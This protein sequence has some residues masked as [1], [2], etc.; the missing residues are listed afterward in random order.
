TAEGLAALLSAWRLMDPNRRGM[1]AAAV[2]ERVYGEGNEFAAWH[3]AMKETLDGLLDKPTGPKLAYLLRSYRRRV[4]GG[5]YFDQAGERNH[6]A[7]WAV[8]PA[9]AIHA[10]QHPPHPSGDGSDKG[11]VSPQLQAVEAFTG[12][13]GDK[14]LLGDDA[15]PS[16]RPERDRVETA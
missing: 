5:Y 13:A 1:T 7:L 2:V 8:F 3:G 12:D 9:Q 16:R 10:G 14:A 15:S 11:D 4:V 6:S